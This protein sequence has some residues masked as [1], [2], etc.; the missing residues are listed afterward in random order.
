[1]QIT[2]AYAN[3]LLRQLNDEKKYWRVKEQNSCLY[4]AAIDETPVIPEYDYGEISDRLAGID[5]QVVKIKHALNQ[6]N[7]ASVIL[8]N[9]LEMTIDSVLVAMSQLNQRKETL[10]AMCEHLPKRRVQAGYG[11]SNRSPEYEYVN[12]DLEQVKKD[13]DRISKEIMDMQIALDL[14]NQTVTFEVDL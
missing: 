9:G 14:H 1:M 10:T 13:C 2:S 8:V 12:Y 7:A 4:T 3:K 6:S 11:R 5:A